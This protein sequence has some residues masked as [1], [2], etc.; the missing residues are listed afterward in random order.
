MSESDWAPDARKA[1]I[2]E[3]MPLAQ[4]RGYDSIREIEPPYGGPGA[5]MYILTREGRRVGGFFTLDS[6]ERYLNL[7]R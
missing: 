2:A 5:G 3:L 7:P 4:E 6:L 1:R